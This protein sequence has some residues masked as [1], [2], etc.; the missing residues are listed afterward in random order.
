MRIF[1][2]KEFLQIFR[3]TRSM[4]ILF[5]IP[6]V[7]VLLFGFALKN[8]LKNVPIAILD[9]SKDVYTQELSH[10]IL[11]SG[12][13]VL[14]EM[15]QSE[16]DI[17][18]I[19]KKGE[20]KE[21]IVFESDFGNKLIQT[22]QADLQII[23][24]ASDPNTANIV[25]SY[26][27][28]IVRDYIEELNIS[29]QKPV[30]IIPQTQMQ[31]NREL[32]SV[33]MFVPGVI[34]IILM[35]VS[36]MMTSIS[37]TREKELGTMEVLLVSP[38]KPWQIIIGKVIPYVILS[39]IN[40]VI[41]LL[42][43]YFV[44][45]MPFSGSLTL[46]LSVSLLFIVL[47]LSLGLFIS[48]VSD[49]QQIAMLLSMFALLL[50]TILLSGYIFPIK[51]MPLILQ[52]LSDLMPA[53]WFIIVIKNIIIKGNGFALVWKEILVLVAMTVFFIVLSVK[54]FKIRLS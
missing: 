28:S 48:T 54:K 47:S 13:F 29:S 7:Q 45:E 3:D 22:Q 42:I 5:G 6:I 18:V 2:I 40:A 37:I 52:Y 46:L 51:N 33:F 17:E 43:S 10:K 15:L 21:V 24:D 26:T 38:V 39:F 1:I 14:E 4:I 44:F 35:L 30:L 12:Y 23:T 16:K 34:A 9:Q 31:Y 53:K 20:V 49:T 11:S 19:F 50:P 41:I 36:T 25:Y 8:E 27:Q 32:K